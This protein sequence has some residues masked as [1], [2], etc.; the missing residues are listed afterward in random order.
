M[1]LYFP[2]KILPHKRTPA[3]MASHG[4]DEQKIR[5]YI[6]EHEKHEKDEMTNYA[7]R[8]LLGAFLIP[9]VLMVVI[10]YF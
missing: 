4:Q 8:L 10:D 1:H 7:L 9:P 2:I 3:H 6:Q 5:R